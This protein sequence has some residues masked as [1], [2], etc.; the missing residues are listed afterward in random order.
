M[1]EV[2]LP[3]IGVSVD[4]VAL[5]ALG[6]TVGFVSAFFGIGGGVISVPMLHILFGIPYNFA[7]GTSPAVIFG[8]TVSGTLGHRR[9][10]HV[11]YKLGAYM[12]IGAVVGVELGTSVVEVLKRAGTIVIASRRIEAVD[13]VLPLIY[14][15]ILTLMGVLFYLESV[16]R[17]RELRADPSAPFVAP[18]SR[19]IRGALWP[20]HISLPTSGIERISL[21]TIVGFGLAQGF[22]AGLLGVGGGIVL[23]PV[24]IYLLGIP[25]VV[26]IGT[27]LF[28]TVF[29]SGIAT[30]SHA[31]KG[32]C[33][34]VLAVCL[35]VG[36]TVGAQI[37]AFVVRKLRG[38]QIR[39]A[40]AF[41]ACA[42]AAVVVLKV[43]VKLGF[44]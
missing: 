32:N 21:W 35:L 33:D 42:V 18:L 38:V 41:L 11:D 9:D 10:Q 12:V 39:R 29:A 16:R 37:G 1:F 3:V 31:R 22:V 13:F 34:I 2:T 27:S 8:T 7:V 20:P 19:F 5:V 25:T 17:I 24:L 44:F 23:V 30:L 4:A 28:A 15:V 26:A 36:S 40:F 43:L 6:V 14:A